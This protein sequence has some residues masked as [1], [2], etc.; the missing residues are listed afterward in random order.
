[1]DKKTAFPAKLD[2]FKKRCLA[3]LLDDSSGADRS[4]L[5]AAAENISLE[6]VNLAIK[7][8]ANNLFVGL[9]P[10]R[11]SAFLLSPMSRPRTTVGRSS[12]DNILGTARDLNMCISVEAREGVT[13]GI[14]AADR[15]VTVRVLGEKIPT[16]RKL[17]KPGHIFPVEVREGGVL[18]N[19][20]LP[21]GAVDIVKIAGFSDAALFSDILNA[22][23]ELTSKNDLEKL[24]SQHN[25]PVFTLAEVTQY[26]LQN[27]VLITRMAE[28]KLPTIEAGELKAIIYKSKIH[29]GEHLALVKGKLDPS[30]P[31]LTRIQVESTFAD[32]FGGNTPPSRASI[33]KSLQELGKNETGIL[34]YL[35]RPVRGLLRD[36]VAD[37]QN[38]QN[39]HSNSMVREYG[40]GSQILLDLGVRKVEL[41]TNSPRDYSGVKSFGIEIVSQKL[42]NP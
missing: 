17:I 21:E 9:S 15:H 42:L 39:S 8:S 12:P 11:A 13:T 22:E 14:S 25:I 38:F 31:T 6:D 28:A 32:V 23:G 20:A 37:W 4:I 16:P 24:S 2:I 41:L 36:Q 5:F 27:E 40:I 18:V 30:Q 10:E 29:E 35:R 7:I 26:R 19:H 33:V 34:I 3:V 1:M